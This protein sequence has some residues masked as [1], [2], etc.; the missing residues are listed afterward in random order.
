MLQQADLQG[1]DGLR[2]KL[3]ITLGQV[4]LQ[5]VP[6]TT[7]PQI[8][9]RESPT[10]DG[11]PKKGRATPVQKKY[12]SVFCPCNKAEEALL[13]LLIGQVRVVFISRS[14]WQTGVQEFSILPMAH[15][16]LHSPTSV[17]RRSCTRRGV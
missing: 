3:C 11:V 6:D 8:L 1:L 5:G 12:E 14:L 17:L 9:S 15:T 2:V 16:L 10:T 4:L 13:V 7:W